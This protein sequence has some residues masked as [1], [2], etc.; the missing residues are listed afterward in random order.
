MLGGSTESKY[1]ILQKLNY[2]TDDPGKSNKGATYELR[3]EV[4]DALARDARDTAA[5]AKPYRN[6]SH[7][8]IWTQRHNPIS[9]KSVG[10][11][12]STNGWDYKY[13]AG[14]EEHPHCGPFNGLSPL[15][16]PRNDC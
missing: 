14:N 15:N 2:F 1:S 9:V 4:T 3:L 16:D 5:L 8:T 13:I 7:H 12:K 11:E 6:R 10:G